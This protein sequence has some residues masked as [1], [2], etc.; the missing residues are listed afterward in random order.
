MLP[1]N[2]LMANHNQGMANH[3]Q[4]MAN[5][6]LVMANLLNK[7]P[8]NLSTMDSSRELRLVLQCRLKMGHGW[9]RFL[10]TWCLW[11]AHLAWSILPS[12]I[13]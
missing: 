9:D 7:W 3:N 13:N 8:C 4:G 12:L 1:L 6:N 5:H 2:R 10:K 11:T